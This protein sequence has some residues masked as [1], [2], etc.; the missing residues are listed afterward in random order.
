MQ[1]TNKQKQKKNPVLSFVYDI[2]DILIPAMILV[3]FIFSFFFRTAGVSGDSMNDTLQ[4]ND[5][6]IVSNCLFYP[7]Y[8]DIVIVNRYHA[9]DTHAEEPLI[10]RVIGLPGDTIRV[11]EDAV[12]RNDVKL[13]EPYVNYKNI[14]NGIT[15]TVE[16]G[17]VFVMGDHRDDSSD[18]RY[19]GTFKIED[20]VGKAIYRYLPFEKAGDI[21]YK[22]K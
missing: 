2:F 13:D 6:L 8:Q 3:S 17:Q 7:D 12:Y 5:R 16:E 1:Y 4:N 20:I 14:P 10:K 19:F 21:R 15:T 9:G 22:S 11:E 18:S